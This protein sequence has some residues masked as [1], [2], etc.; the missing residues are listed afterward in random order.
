MLVERR[1][2]CYDAKSMKLIYLLMLAVLLHEWQV[3]T[4]LRAF[5]R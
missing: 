4:D 5:E 2:I 1:L 3:V